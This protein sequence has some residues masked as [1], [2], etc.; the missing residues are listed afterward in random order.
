M[1]YKNLLNNPFKFFKRFHLLAFVV[2]SFILVSCCSSSKTCK[3]ELTYYTGTITV[4]GNEPFTNLALQV[5]GEETF[6]LECEEELA[7]QLWKEQGAEYKIGFC[8]TKKKSRGTALIVVK[9]EQIQ[10][11]N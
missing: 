4:V 1:F 2:L 5:E 9:A 7:A 3:K 6:L 10:K 11:E 8:E